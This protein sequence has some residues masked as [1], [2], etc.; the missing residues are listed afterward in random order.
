MMMRHRTYKLL[1][2]GAIQNSLMITIVNVNV[3]VVVL[4]GIV[5]TSVI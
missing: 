1:V 5:I 4:V 2:L 3:V